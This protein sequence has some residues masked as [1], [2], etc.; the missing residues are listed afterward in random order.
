MSSPDKTKILKNEI[1]A[2]AGE[3]GIEVVGFMK[4]D[5]NPIMPE[6]EKNLLTGVKYTEGDID[7]T[8][9]K[10]PKDQM[11]EARSMIILGKRLLD[12]KQDIL[13]HVSDSYMTSIE[14]MILDIASLKLHKLL[15]Q[16]GFKAE[17]NTSYY[18]K[19]W[20]VLA[21][22]G[23]I[24]KSRMF[25]SKD[26]GPRLRLKGILT[27][28]DIGE[29]C[30]II[31]DATCGECQECIDACPVKAISDEAYDRRICS[32]CKLNNRK[33]SENAYSYCTMCTRSCPVGKL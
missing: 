26:H 16:N 18:L 12:D 17:D 19:V 13:Y 23:W 25:V 30:E 21:G 4:L 1:K 22:L 15:E 14:F 5:G 8:K 28:A 11:P 20:A 10:N 7:I 6:D 3:H 27:D 29:E 33:V 31:S 9:I 32:T 24:G 2:I